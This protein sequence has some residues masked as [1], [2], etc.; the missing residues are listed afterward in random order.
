MQ[1][2]KITIQWEIFASGKNVPILSLAG[3]GENICT[4][5]STH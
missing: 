3:S 5:E 1:Q 2:I 4:K